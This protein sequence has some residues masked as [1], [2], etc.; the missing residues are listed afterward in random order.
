MHNQ[1][2]SHEKTITKKFTESGYVITPEIESIFSIIEENIKD[3]T[4]LL[5]EL[6]N[7]IQLLILA[8]KTSELELF[9]THKEKESESDEL[10]ILNELKQIINEQYTISKNALPNI[11]QKLFVTARREAAK[12]YNFINLKMK[13]L[14]KLA[15]SDESEKALF[16]KLRNRTSKAEIK[17]ISSELYGLKNE[18]TLLKLIPLAKEIRASNERLKKINES[19]KFFPDEIRE[20]FERFCS[21]ADENIKIAWNRILE[22]TRMVRDYN[23]HVV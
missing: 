20:T 15:E 18:D 4:H 5:D 14:I 22:I 16:K 19:N 21:T 9:T 23:Y 6:K 11:K 7:H 17:E 13:E 10:S 1:V 3:Q 8:N 2:K 12:E